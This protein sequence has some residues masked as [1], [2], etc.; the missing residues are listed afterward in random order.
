MAKGINTSTAIDEINLDADEGGLKAAIE[1]A[2]EPEVKV[3]EP[4]VEEKPKEN[5]DEL[6]TRI[7][8]LDSKISSLTE[9][10]SSLKHERYQAPVI[11]VENKPQITNFNESD[12][13]M[14][15]K[16][17]DKPTEVLNNLE[18]RLESKIKNDML[19]QQ[20]QQ[21]LQKDWENVQ[22]DPDFVKYKDK[23]QGLMN[24]RLSYS[25]FYKLLKYEDTIKELT[26]LKKGKPKQPA[27]EEG[28]PISS[29][30]KI[31]GLTDAEKKIAKQ[32]GL[33]EEQYKTEQSKIKKSMEI[34]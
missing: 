9:T 30:K 29:G 11:P 7:K 1:K 6:H 24:K 20:I 22:Q 23:W 3:E 13:E 14:R 10:I 25:D 18:K 12:D 26:E 8:D 17:Y 32:F 31:D 28:Q 34:K 16:L 15:T 5:T 19:Q 27:I 21:E 33:T 2:K 4:V